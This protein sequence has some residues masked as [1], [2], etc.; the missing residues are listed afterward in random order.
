MTVGNSTPEK[1]H[2]CDSY[3]VKNVTDDK[4]TAS[5]I[6]SYKY[7]ALKARLSNAQGWSPLVSQANPW[8]QVDFGREM[9]IRAV[10]TKGMGGLMEWVKK[11]QVIYSNT[12][13]TW[14]VVQYGSSNVRQKY[15]IHVYILMSTLGQIKFSSS[16]HKLM[17]RKVH[18]VV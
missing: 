18:F 9:S 2:A 14:M 8:I 3:L 13:S 7:P 6:Y 4:L 1:V 10:L 15:H 16:F 17:P 11:Y 12:A 5:S